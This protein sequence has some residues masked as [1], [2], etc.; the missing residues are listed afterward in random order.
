[1]LLLPLQLA[2]TEKD[3][4]LLETMWQIADGW[5]KNW[6]TWKKG[7]FS[8]LNVESMEMTAATFNKQIG[9][10]RDIK[11]WGVWTMMRER[12]DRFRATLP[13][14][15]DLRNPALRDRHWDMVRAGVNWVWDGG[16]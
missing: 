1:M 14:I 7:Q 13:L 9:K 11:R 6:N 16:L 5:E 2:D 10:M 15:Q 8:A 3:L 12:I 4:E